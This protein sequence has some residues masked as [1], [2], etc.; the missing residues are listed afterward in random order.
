M[1]LGFQNMTPEGKRLFKQLQELESLE[2]V[3]GFQGDQSYDDG[4]SLAEV[5]AYN[6]FGSSNTPARP[7]MKQSFENHEDALK[8]GCKQ[9]DITISKGGTAQQALE[10][11]GVMAKGLVQEEIVNGGFAPNAESTIAMKGSATPLVD[12]GYMRQSVNYVIRKRR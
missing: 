7:F 9:V 12:S 10:K 8:A 4:T 11:L 1:A 2:V 3:V 5:A 6:E